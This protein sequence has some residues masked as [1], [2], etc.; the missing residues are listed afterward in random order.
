M[1]CNK[2]QNAVQQFL[3][4][5]TDAFDLECAAHRSGCAACQADYLAALRLARGV[6]LLEKPF[7]PSGF[8]DR[9]S[10]AVLADEIRPSTR[11][12]ARRWLEVLAVAASLMLFIS[13]G[14]RFISHSKTPPPAAPEVATI[15]DQNPMALDQSFAEASSAVASLG[16]RTADQAIEP[17]R[18]LIATAADTPVLKAEP[19]ADVVK[20]ADEALAPIREGAAK[21]FEPVANSARRAVSLFMRDLTLDNQ[22]KRDF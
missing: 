20:P 2:F 16:R 4:G 11:G 12:A 9:V 15:P 13:L 14:M 18:R 6:Q 3:D 17:A 1:A 8:L 5:R 7:P 21:S 22:R 10:A 19:V